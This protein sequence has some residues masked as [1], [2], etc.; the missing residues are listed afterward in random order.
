MLKLI[1]PGPHVWERF[2]SGAVETEECAHSIF[3]RWSRAVALGAKADG[4]AHSAGVT[5][6]ELRSRRESLTDRCVDAV[7]LV[8]RLVTETSAAEFRA[9]LTDAEGVVVIAGGG[10]GASLRMAYTSQ[11]V[12]GACWAESTRGTN[13][14][15]TAIAEGEPVTVVGRAHL[16][17]RNHG[18]VCYAA[19]IRDPFGDLVAV[20]DVS[21]AVAQANPLL[22]ALV[23]ASAHAAEQSLRLRY[24]EQMLVGG[25][26]SLEARL[27]G[28]ASLLVEAPGVIR[29]VSADA[30]AKLGHAPSAI[31]GRSVED[32]LS[33]SWNALVE[34]ALSNRACRLSGMRLHPVPH[35]DMRGRPLA[36]AVFIERDAPRARA[37]GPLPDSFDALIGS[38]PALQDAKQRAARV[39]RSPLPVLLLAETGTGK[40]LLA[41]AIHEASGNASGPFLALNCGAMPAGLLESELFGYAP[42]AFTGALAAGSKGKLG[43]ADGGTLFLDEIGEMPEPLQALLLRVLDDGHYFRLGETRPRESR[44][45]LISATCRDLPA[46]VEAGK[47]RRDLYYRI[48]GAGVSLPPLRQRTDKIELARALVEKLS[49]EQ[50][51]AAPPMTP[52]TERLIEAHPWPGNV[53]ELKSALAHALVLAGEGEPLAPEHLPD[54]VPAPSSTA[55]VSEGGSRKAAEARALKDAMAAANGNL[56]EAARRLGVARSTLYR[57]LGR[58]GL[59]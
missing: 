30:A 40:E 49:R 25:S 32:I 51:C 10:I 7:Q 42:G 43:A 31:M 2:V 39:A 53:R 4:P 46:M 33:L 11:L 8:S 13:A 58:H 41:R 45:R 44:F 47:F 56:S 50:G 59:S 28:S 5:D 55:A 6:A 14:I 9:V 48:R 26:R 54:D 19:P 36:L 38:D 52:G 27:A 17:E 23:L 3:H 15:G 34:V 16:E 24:Y 18:L 37:A 35:F 21:G 57:M 22:E 29:Q 12:E 1:E 20:L